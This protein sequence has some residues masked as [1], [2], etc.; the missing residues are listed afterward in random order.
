MASDII[1]RPADVREKEKCHR[2]I[3]RV[4]QSTFNLHFFTPMQGTTHPLHSICIIQ[5]SFVFHPLMYFY[6]CVV[7]CKEKVVSRLFSPCSNWHA[8]CIE[9]GGKKFMKLCCWCEDAEFAVELR[10]RLS[11]QVRLSDSISQVLFCFP[12]SFFFRYW[13]TQ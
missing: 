4:K 6:F 3:P 5:S 2:G 13:E 7:I 10:R 9:W 11:D 1:M 8:K 12:S